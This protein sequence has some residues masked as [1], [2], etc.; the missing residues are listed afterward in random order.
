LARPVNPE[1][2]KSAIPG[3]IEGGLVLGFTVV[4][5][6]AAR[7]GMERLALALDGARRIPL[8]ARP[9]RATLAVR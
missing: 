9:G 5:S 2:G 6:D 8:R 1:G 7:R 3:E 4:R